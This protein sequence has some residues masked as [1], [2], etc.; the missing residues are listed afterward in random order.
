MH[1]IPL[2]LISYI[3]S[4]LRDDNAALS[5]CSLCCSSFACASRP[6]LFHT[7]RTRLYFEPTDRLERLLELEPTVL[8]LIKRIEVTILSFLNIVDTIQTVSQIATRCHKEYTSLPLALN[9]AIAPTRPSP[10]LEN[11]TLLRLHP[12]FDWVTSLELDGL[13]LA[14]DTHFWDLVLSFR[15]LKSLVLGHV[16]VGEAGGDAPSHRKS[17]ISHVSLR[18]SALAGLNSN[19]YRF[20]ADHP[21]PL[22]SLTSLD[23][24][25]PLLIDRTPVRFGGHYGPSVR[26]LRFGIQVIRHLTAAHTRVDSKTPLPHFTCHTVLTLHIKA[27]GEFISQFN[28][29]EELTFQGLVPHKPQ[30]EKIPV[31]FEW[32]P[33]ILCRVTPTIRKFTMETVADDLSRLD[34]IPWSAID[35][36]LAHQLQSVITVEILL[37]TPIGTRRLLDNV[38]Q[39]VG[40]KLPLAAQ[41]GILR[42]V[43]VAKHPD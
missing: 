12:L 8:P 30:P 23:V 6:L 22:P 24:R 2:E 4:F 1:R 43:A 10:P 29:L 35:E 31:T 9:L 27:A 20:L 18:P 42:C 38:Y 25:F 39:D 16:H 15:A 36:I 13:N 19:I 14:Q 7:L 33:I 28:N 5:A 3:I 11:S 32:I 26:A 37:A 34:F 41:R 17:K 40:K 21:I